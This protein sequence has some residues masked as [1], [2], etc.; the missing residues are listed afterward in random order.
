MKKL[1]VAVMVLAAVLLVALT[2]L[3]VL[4]RQWFPAAL[5]VLAA[6]FLVRGVMQQHTAPRRSAR[7]RAA[8]AR[9]TKPRVRTTVAGTAGE[10]AAVRAVRRADRELSMADAV[11]LVRSVRPKGSATT[12][13]RRSS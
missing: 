11:A 3:S 7:S 13:A 1:T 8:A 6:A 4:D 5:E 2:V 10:V 12:R 9:W